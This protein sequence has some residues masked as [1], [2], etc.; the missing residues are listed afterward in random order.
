MAC[1]LSKHAL[2]A[3]LKSRQNFIGHKGLDRTGKSAAV[4]TASALTLQ[5]M[6]AHRQSKRNI[7]MRFISGRNHILQIHIG[8]VT[9]FLYQSQKSIEIPM[10][11]RR[12]L[13]WNTVI[14]LIEVNCTKHCT[15]TAFFTKLRNRCEEIR[16]IYLC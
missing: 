11:Q 3:C 13:L 6:I 12:N 2:N 16:R 5:E 8:S 14:L 9:A 4:D 7:L 10:L 15:V 1:T